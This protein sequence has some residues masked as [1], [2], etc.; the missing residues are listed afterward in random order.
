M[1]P[2]DI[3]HLR[4]TWARVVS[5]SQVFGFLFYERLFTLAPETR[6]LF[7]RSLD[8]QGQKLFQTLNWIVANIDDTERVLAE[9]RELAIRHIGYGVEAGDYPAVGEALV[10]AMDRGL[11]T[12]LSEAEAAAWQR[13]YAVLSGAMI[14]AAYPDGAGG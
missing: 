1:D 14:A 5:E 4:R 12:G 3:K 2:E 8:V 13:A 9:A 11:E 6:T 7:P 10:S